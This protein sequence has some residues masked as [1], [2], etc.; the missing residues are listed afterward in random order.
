MSFIPLG[1]LA[2]SGGGSA[3]SFESIATYTATGG[4]TTITLSSIPQT[5]KHLQ[6]RCITKDA[7]TASSGAQELGIRFNGDSGSNY[8]THRLQAN[9]AVIAQ[10]GSASTAIIDRSPIINIYGN[11]SNYYGAAIVDI[12]QYSSTSQYKTLRSFTGADWNTP[13]GKMAMSSGSWMNT[14]AITSIAITGFISGAAAGSKY[15]LYGIK[16]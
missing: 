6:L 14:A 9:S 12:H 2:A 15:A 3:P 8:S 10:S 4:E 7:Y 16:G 13:D 5:F 11:L 1:V